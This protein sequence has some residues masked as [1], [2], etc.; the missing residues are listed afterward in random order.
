MNARTSLALLTLTSVLLA[1]CAGS[2]APATPNDAQTGSLPDLT[3]QVGHEH[4]VTAAPALPAT[5]NLQRLPDLRGPK[6]RERPIGTQAI[7]ANP[8]LLALKLLIITAGT[9]DPDLDAAKAMLGQAGVPYDV[10][11]ATTTPLTEDSLMVA[12]DGSGRYQGVILTNNSLFFQNSNGGYESALDV[13][14]WATLWQYEQTFKVR[15]LSMYTFPG[16][17]PEDYGMRY[18]DGTASD[19]ADVVAA[20]GQTITSEFRP[21]AVVKVRNAYNYPA[22]VLDPVSWNG[23]GVA[24]VQPVL[25]DKTSP[26]RVFAATST[27]TSG[28]ERLALTM[29]HNQYFLHSQLLG[30]SLVNWVTKGLYLG[31]YRRYNQL[32]IDD[33][34]LYGDH[35]NAA[36]KTLSPDS[37][38]MSASDALGARD[39]Q[40]TLQNTFD[41]ARGFRFAVA[42]NGGGANTAAAASCDPNVGGV[43]PLTS[44]TKC[45]AGAFN[46]VSHTRDHLYMDFLNTTQSTTQ[47]RDNQTI[48]ATLGL[49][50]STKGLITGDMSGLGYYNAAG[51]GPKTNYGLSA[52]NPSSCRSHLESLSLHR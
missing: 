26:S 19:S 20:P 36:T 21:G 35:Y 2:P 4:L 48:G 6:I 41:V 23:V 17:F 40:T 46:W 29:A 47:I 44:M 10:L 24:N 51:D 5:P 22:V 38:R 52:S 45:L 37:F 33:W 16:V 28:R 30:Y 32:D 8:N 34:F 7:T 1:A 49:V 9:A 43:D 31:E 13:N 3:S 11:D 27:T 12:A 50:R 39:Q 15:Q 18:L 14:E 25:V 42:Y